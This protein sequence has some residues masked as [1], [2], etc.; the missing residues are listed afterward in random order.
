MSV[1][2]SSLIADLAAE[3]SALDAMLDG[4]ASSDWAIPTPA[5]GWDVTDTISHIFYFDEA[6]CLALSD[7]PA[8]DVKLNALI[9]GSLGPTCDVDPGREMGP[10]ELL[11][12]WRA[13]RV[14]LLSTLSSADPTAR[15]PWFG[16]AMSLASFTTARLME[17][18]AH[19]VDVADALDLPV[20]VS[21]R[22]KHVCHIGVGARAYS[23][24]ARGVADPGNP[25]RVELESPTG[26]VWSWGPEDAQ[27]RVS[28]TALDFAVLVT[29]RR[30]L[31]DTSLEVQGEVAR[32]W[33]SIAQAFAGPD[34]GGR[35]PGLRPITSSAASIAHT[36]D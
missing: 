13:G 23:F 19:G 2:Q 31:A 26:D 3:H 28:G 7:P 29:Q 32:Q 10:D 20:V 30:H 34:G 6:A 11:R 22:L 9:S 33:I 14:E 18:W 27:D 25:I 16:P 12:R 5:A 17:T 4:R 24:L 15:V 1:V 35:S 36:I 21:A 8:F